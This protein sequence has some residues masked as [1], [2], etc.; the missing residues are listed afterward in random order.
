MLDLGYSAVTLVKHKAL[1]MVERMTSSGSFLA[2]ISVRSPKKLFIFI[3]YKKKS[4]WKY[5]K[6]N[7]F[8]FENRSIDDKATLLYQHWPVILF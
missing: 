5:S 3:I 6:N 8:N 2:K 7:L 1:A 4:R